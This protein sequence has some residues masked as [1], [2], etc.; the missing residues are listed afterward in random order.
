[1]RHCGCSRDLAAGPSGMA[2]AYHLVVGSLKDFLSMVFF[3]V[4]PPTHTS[5][6]LIINRKNGSF[7]IE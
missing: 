2:S 3:M 1:M 7:T 5:K 4:L 6:P